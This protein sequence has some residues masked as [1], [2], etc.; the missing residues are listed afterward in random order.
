MTIETLIWIA[1]AALLVLL[2]A[3]AIWVILRRRT[4]H[5]DRQRQQVRERA[6]EARQRTLSSEDRERYSREWRQIQNAFLDRP[7]LAL[8]E[9]ERLVHDLMRDRG[10]TVENFDQAAL[11][12]SV[13]PESLVAR[14]RD[15]QRL[16]ESGTEEIDEQR[17]AMLDY[18]AVV[19]ELL[20]IDVRGDR[21]RVE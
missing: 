13:E 20:A 10:Y 9:A 19:D 16:V 21:R 12:L 11:D 15:A 14:Y 6:P 5:E 4:T 7:S 1:S 3:V 18:R 8:V 17:R 2:A